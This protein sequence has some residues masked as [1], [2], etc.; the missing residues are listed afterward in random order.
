MDFT[1]ALF[2]LFDQFKH[3][4]GLQDV[5]SNHPRWDEA[6]KHVVKLAIKPEH[7]EQV[8]DLV[9]LLRRRQKV[10]KTLVVWRSK[11]TLLKRRLAKKY[12]K[13]WIDSTNFRRNDS[14]PDVMSPVIDQVKSEVFVKTEKFDMIDLTMSS[15]APSCDESD[16]TELDSSESDSD[17]SSSSEDG[18]LS[19]WQK[20]SAGDW[21]IKNHNFIDRDTSSDFEDDTSYESDDPAIDW[22][23]EMTEVLCLREDA[24]K[25]FHWEDDERKLHFWL[26]PDPEIKKESMED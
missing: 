22:D 21:T 20:Y 18:E 24:Q 9:N 10:W 3:P 7:L 5:I 6:K 19:Q 23:V 25:N 2:D 26:F 13:R 14:N 1:E 15:P 8:V 4:L 16:A 17:C 12:L 11:T